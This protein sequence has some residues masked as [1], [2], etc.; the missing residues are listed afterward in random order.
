M[1]ACV[2]GGGPSG[3]YIS[4]YLTKYGFNIELFEKSNSLLG[5]YKY[6][7]DKIDAIEKISQNPNITV[8]LNSDETT[9]DDS[10][11]DFYILAT[12]AI[13]KELDIKGKQHLTKAI[14][15]IKD[16][17]ENKRL[18]VKGDICIIGMG[19]VALDLVYY[20]KDCVRSIT[21]LS[22]GSLEDAAFDN[23]VMR[24][25]IDSDY[26]E[27]NTVNSRLQGEDIV[28]RKTQR[29]FEM[30][31]DGSSTVKP[32]KENKM[33]VILSLFIDKLK[34]LFSL[35][36]II[37][38][39]SLLKNTCDQKSLLKN[40]NCRP[41]LNL[42]FKATP[43]SIIKEND[44]SLRLNYLSNNKIKTDLFDTIISSVGFQSYLPNISTCKKVYS[45][46]WCSNPRGNIGDSK[47]EARDKAKE[48][49]EEQL[50]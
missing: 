40:N 49:A 41:S 3:L 33:G 39:K 36:R 5:N 31:K 26:F 2:I 9:V 30:F 35:E 17:Y 7:R 28:D 16:Y 10:S 24:G 22:R 37:P 14:D 13:Q 20:L 19:N 21:V 25:I 45:V 44:G 32:F 12:G 34:N 48:I 42:I 6:A 23:H 11:C 43:S 18:N 1:K 15:M 46:G 50:V 27:I 4:D 47:L 8:H 38:Q 29:R